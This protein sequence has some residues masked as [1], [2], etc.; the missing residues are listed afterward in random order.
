VTIQYVMLEV[1]G[2]EVILYQ[3][4]DVMIQYVMMEVNLDTSPLHTHHN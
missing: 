3:E 2:S 1:Q 4:S